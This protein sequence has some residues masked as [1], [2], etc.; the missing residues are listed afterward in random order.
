MKRL[1]AIAVVVGLASALTLTGCST[2]E[3]GSSTEQAPPAAKSG[4]EV[5][6]GSLLDSEGAILGSMIVQ[7]LEANGIKT[8]D[9]TKLGTPD[10][11][12]QA[13]LEGDIDITVDYTGSGQYYHEG[14]EGAKVW[15]DAQAGY[16]RI[17]ELDR[18]VNDIWWLAPA[19]ANNTELICTTKTLARRENLKTMEDFAA[20]V[21][22]GKPV[23]L[24]GA[25]SWRDNPQGLAGFEKAYGFTIADDQMIALSHG[26]T[27]EMLKALA[28]GT[29]G[30]NF[31]LC[32]GTDG[33]LD[34]LGLVVL[35]DTKG[36]PP[37]YEPAPVVRGEIM[38]A[39]P[40]IADILAPVFASLDLTTLQT[41][42]SRVALGGEDAKA[43]AKDYLATN[44]F[45]K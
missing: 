29:D 21:N 16:A 23:K 38:D 3:V 8:V 37:V 10:V 30:V 7:M 41:L 5:R 20:Y 19:P 2:A 26:N 22:A 6:V 13:L 15:S 32:Y 27:A 31:S 1:T 42:N 28:N 44:G 12:R 33:Q 40:Q 24:I 17:A 39:Y 9:K 18:S 25:Q 35:E 4:P 45:L 43:V 11:V 34:D 36:V 14:E